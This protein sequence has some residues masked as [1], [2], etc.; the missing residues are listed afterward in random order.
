MQR[1]TL[2]FPGY[3]EPNPGELFGL[4]VNNRDYLTTR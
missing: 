4:L 3:P 2:D 1:I